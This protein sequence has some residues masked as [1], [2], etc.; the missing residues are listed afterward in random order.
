[1][2]LL[3]SFVHDFLTPFGGN[4]HLGL[5]LIV[6]FSAVFPLAPPEEAF[7]LLG[8]ACVAG[9]FLHWFWGS[10][11]IL[12]GIIA[13]NISQ[14]WMGR[15]GLKLLS[16]T[17]LGN[18]I[19]HSRGFRRARQAMLERG[20]WAIVGCRFFFGTRA[21]TYLATGFFR[22]RFWKFAAVDSSVVV[23]HGLVFIL[24]G[25]YFS[26]Q[27][28]GVLNFMGERGLWSLLLLLAAVGVFIGLRIY[29]ARRRAAPIPP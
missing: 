17:R 22:Y 1:L 4:P 19:I 28:G 21:P 23:V 8:G 25:T 20:I 26:D 15:A 29:L 11:A 2:D 7:T 10:L 27:I 6:W 3:Q 5:F 16:G 14:Y 18:R 13:T 9:G 24:I 12:G